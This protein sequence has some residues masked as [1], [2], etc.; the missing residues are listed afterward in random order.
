MYYVG[1]F[2]GTETIMIPFNTFS[3]DDPSASV[4]ISDLAAGDV[5]IHKDGSLTQ[6]SSDAG[7]AVD[8]DVDGVTG[9]HWITIDLSDNT[10]AGFYSSGS[11]FAVRMEGTTV[12]GATINAW[13]GTF[14][15]GKIQTAV[16]AAL[17][18][19][20]LDH[21][22]LTA[23]AA[24]DM[25]TEVADNTI[26]SRMIASG[27]TSAFD[28]TTDSLQDIRDKLT[29]I[30]TDTDVIDDG[31]SGLVKI[32]SDVAAVLVDTGTTLPG[33][34]TTM[35]GKIDTV[36]TN[37]DSVLTDTGTTLPA[38]LTT[39]EGKVD[40][41]DTVVDAVKLKTDNLPEGIQKNVA[42]S[43]FEFLMVD[44]TDFATPETGL[45][46]SGQRSID[47]AAFAAVTGAIAEVGNG[48]YQFDAAQA[49]TNGDFIT[50][51]FTATGAAATVVSFKTTT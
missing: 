35:E 32:A 21:L 31:T 34:L 45:T 10:D 23:T 7:V 17:T 43:N 48:V 28:P 5:E 51:R 50:W 11:Q 3:S 38:T 13:I 4:I 14:T 1:D 22:C 26:L 16:T 9:N 19:M 49:D 36:D 44:E 24:A 29:D 6:R 37:V 41:V 12:D 39:I 33:T 27:D 20:N 8:I 40:T 18:A 30:E 46:V 42:L 15:I 25:T 47:G 2:A